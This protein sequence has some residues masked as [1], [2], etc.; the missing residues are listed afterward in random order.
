MGI[1]LK[2]ERTTYE[3]IPNGLYDAVCTDIFDIGIQHTSSKEYGDRDTLQC[4]LVWELPELTYT[5]AD[6]NEQRRQLRKTYTQSTSEK[7]NLRKDLESWRGQPF[8][9]EEFEAGWDLDAVL[10]CGCQLQVMQQKSANGNI[11]VNIKNI[12]PLKRDRWAEPSHTTS[13][14]LDN[15]HLDEIDYLPEWVQEKVKASVTYQQLAES[16]PDWEVK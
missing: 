8:T 3:L 6:G 5:D 12:V 4:I 11:Y 16:I 7:S 15:E 2:A 9:E 10:G 13:F 1:I 14:V